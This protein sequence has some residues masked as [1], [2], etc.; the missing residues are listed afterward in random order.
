[1]AHKGRKTQVRLSK[2]QMKWYSRSEKYR[3]WM[4]VKESGWDI[5]RTELGLPLTGQPM[6]VEHFL[7]LCERMENGA[8]KDPEMRMLVDIAYHCHAEGFD[9]LEDRRVRKFHERRPGI[10]DA[11]C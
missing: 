2:S 8:M 10:Y 1:M 4:G 6:D 7:M 9:Y 3:E 5:L 11:M